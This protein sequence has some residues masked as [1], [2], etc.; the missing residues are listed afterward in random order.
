MAPPPIVQ[1]THAQRLATSLENL[2][3]TYVKFGQAL[4]SRPDIV[5]ISLSQALSSLQDGMTPFDTDL[6]KEIVRR[7][8][9]ARCDQV[10]DDD[11]YDD[12]N[13]DAIAVTKINKRNNNNNMPKKKIRAK[14]LE[15]LLSSLTEEPVAAA[16][17]GQV[18]KGYLPSKGNVALKVQRLG[19]RRLV[20]VRIFWNTMMSITMAALYLYSVLTLFV[21]ICVLLTTLS[22]YIYILIDYVLI[23]LLYLE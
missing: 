19:V 4:G 9:F 14:E 12:N 7:E 17:I 23:M 11:D 2:G 15:A 8:L 3:P 6:A 16:S 18:Y 13:N 22:I 10:D 21:L 1:I 20:E 5:P